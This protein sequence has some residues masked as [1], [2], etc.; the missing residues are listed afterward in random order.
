MLAD[1]TFLLVQL[2]VPPRTM[3]TKDFLKQILAEHKELIE[4][5]EV[6]LIKVPF[7]DELSVKNLWPQMKNANDFMKFFP[8]KLPKGRLPD[9]TYFFNVLNTI[10]PEYVAHLIQHA[11]L[12]RNSIEGEKRMAQTI[13]LTDAW[14]E[15]LMAVPFISCKYHRHG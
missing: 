10:S 4:I 2:Y 6:K 15:K 12:Q 14:A 13:E 11:N 8:N 1:H 5:K 7:F 9:R 3:L